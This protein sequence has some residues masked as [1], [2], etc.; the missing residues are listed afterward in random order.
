VLTTVTM[1]VIVAMA[2]VWMSHQGVVPKDHCLLPTLRARLTT[3]CLAVGSCRS[4]RL[5][6]LS[7]PHSQ[8]S[9]LLFRDSSHRVVQAGLELYILLP[10]PPECWDYRPGITP[11]LVA[12]TFF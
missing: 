11:R 8:D 10:Q 12:F 5:V 7:R 6:D 9:K 1:T 4:E 2:L 3:L